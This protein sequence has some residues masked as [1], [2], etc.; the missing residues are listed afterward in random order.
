M[1]LIER[2]A[3]NPKPGDKIEHKGWWLHPTRT[4]VDRYPGVIG[5]VE[6]LWNMRHNL[7]G[8]CTLAEWAVFCDGARVVR[9][10]AKK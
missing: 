2:I 6:Y 5:D 4:V 1:R 7:H 3:T 8:R 10:R 9:T